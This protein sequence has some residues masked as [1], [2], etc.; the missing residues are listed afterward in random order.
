MLDGCRR[1]LGGRWCLACRNY[2]LV[3]II[4]MTS[5]ASYYRS[6]DSMVMSVMSRHAPGE[7]AADAAFSK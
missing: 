5:G 6:G 7:C 1:R 3:L 2:G 4:I